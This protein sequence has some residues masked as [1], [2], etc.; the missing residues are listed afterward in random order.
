MRKNRSAKMTGRRLKLRAQLWPDI[1]N[2]NLWLRDKTSG[3]TTIPRCLSLIARIMD[4][5]SVKKPL[6]NTYL[7]LWCYSFDEMIIT[8]QKPHQMALES[9]F[10][11]QRALSTWRD[12]MKKLE[13]LGFIRSA[14]GASGDFHYIVILNPYLV[15]RTLNESKGYEVPSDLYNTLIERMEEIGEETTMTYEEDD[16]AEQ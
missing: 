13:D 8:V 2:E 10:S 1:K 5:L 12:R 15:I 3:F 7:A 11:G 6:S 14:K 9:G 16:Q 4:S